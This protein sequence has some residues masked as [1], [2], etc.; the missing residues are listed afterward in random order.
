MNRQTPTLDLALGAMLLTLLAS[1]AVAL[2]AAA[3]LLGFALGR[4][5]VLPALQLLGVL[6]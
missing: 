1:W 6:P 4:Y 2:C 3:L 5:V